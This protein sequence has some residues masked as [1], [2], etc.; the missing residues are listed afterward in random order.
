MANRDARHRQVFTPVPTTVAIH[1]RSAYLVALEIGVKARPF[2]TRSTCR[3]SWGRVKL[4]RGLLSLW[5]T[6]ITVTGNFKV[7]QSNC[8]LD[9]KHTCVSLSRIS[10]HAV[11]V[12]SYVVVATRVTLFVAWS[13]LDHVL[14][15]FHPISSRGLPPQV[16]R[17]KVP[18]LFRIV[19]VVT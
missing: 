4:T 17:L 12:C 10:C 5:P 7:V 19:C 2:K 13:S 15:Q 11:T 18:F 16:T 3:R 8:G 9:R 1:C 14:L 6:G